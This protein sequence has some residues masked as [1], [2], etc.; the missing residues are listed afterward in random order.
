MFIDFESLVHAGIDLSDTLQA[1][2]FGDLL[3]RIKRQPVAPRRL[4]SKVPIGCCDHP[5]A[6]VGS[7]AGEQFLEPR[8]V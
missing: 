2:N 1:I 5:K 4:V 6:C 7:S 3:E 8:R